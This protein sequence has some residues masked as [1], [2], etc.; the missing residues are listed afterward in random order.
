MT[1]ETN[2]E[3][4]KELIDSVVGDPKRIP[5]QK[6]T[7]LRFNRE[8]NEINLHSFDPTLVKDLIKHPNFEAE[9]FNK[10][11]DGNIVG[12]MGKLPIGTLK[13]K[14]E[15]RKRDYPSTIIST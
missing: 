8:E 7:V 10:D 6:E 12:I 13:I 5:Y 2:E 14:R 9:Q 3:N 15:P 4:Q 1:K 11:D